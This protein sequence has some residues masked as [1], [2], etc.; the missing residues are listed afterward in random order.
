MKQALI[1][2]DVQNDYFTG[3]KMP[4]SLPERALSQINKLEEHFLKNQLPI[5]YIQH[6][7]DDPQAPFFGRGTKGAQL[8]SDLKV[9]SSSIIIEKQ[10][11]NS[12][13][14]TNLA[15]LLQSLQVQQVVVTGMMT[16]MCIDSTTRAS[17]ERGYQPILISD[18]TT[19]RKLKVQER[20]VLADEVQGAFIAALQN[21]AQVL[22]TKDYLRQ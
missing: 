6:I 18:A 9:D 22:T 1:V 17:A 7:K 19:T 4:L 14:Q 13:L 16:H 15:Q 20:E 5:I 8:H 21:F 12:F 3:G 2:V 11:P 10:Y